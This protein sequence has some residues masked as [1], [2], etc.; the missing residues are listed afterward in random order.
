[1]SLGKFTK[2]QIFRQ[3][4]SG[5]LTGS[6]EISGRP[7]EKWQKVA[8]HPVFYDEFMK[9]LLG[10][11]F[12][13]ES[14]SEKSAVGSLSRVPPVADP[15]IPQQPT[16]R[17]ELEEEKRG[18]VGPTVQAKTEFMDGATVQESDLR[19]LFSES[20]DK[21][22]TE[23]VSNHEDKT[24]RLDEAL[25]ADDPSSQLIPIKVSPDPLGTQPLTERSFPASSAKR[26]PA[27]R[28]AAFI[29]VLGVLFYVSFPSFYQ[30][31]VP[32]KMTQE[33]GSADTAESLTEREKDDRVRSLLEEG[34]EYYRLDL[35]P[36]YQQAQEIYREAL[37]HY[38]TNPEALARIAETTARI[39]PEIKDSKGLE[40]AVREWLEKGRAIDPHFS[41][42]YR[43]EAL[44]LLHQKRVDEASKALASAMETNATDPDN[45]IV[46]AEIEWAK[47]NTLGAKLALTE[48]IHKKSPDVRSRLLLARLFLN[49]NELERAQKIAIESLS[50]NPLAPTAYWILGNIALRVNSLAQAKQHFES[51]RN[52]SL[53]ATRE[54]AGSSF[55]ELGKIMERLNETDQASLYF[56]VAYFYNPE[57]VGL[58]EKVSAYSL[59][60]KELG[61]LAIDA[62]YTRE[63]LQSRGDQF[64]DQGKYAEAGK[65]FLAASLTDRKDGNSLVRLGETIENTARSFVD[66]QKVINLY[67]RAIQRDPTLVSGYVRLGLLETTQ[68]NFDRAHKLLGQALALAPN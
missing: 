63:A 58:R 42:F 50:I 18:G 60:E 23:K 15:E 10:D 53:F 52:L 35:P 4:S 20:I 17:A 9:R 32:V 61:K 2:E 12:K 43:V 22:G 30:T 41:P 62:A 40:R 65:F 66:F 25:P 51:A 24:A 57:I 59:E 21:A 8:S 16:R 39:I 13:G 26:V 56:R 6:E 29:L 1:M 44:I 7:F 48:A 37:F 19:E 28:I 36:A 49:E 64:F 68:Y 14:P 67:Q 11:E 33:A 3:I 54:V 31:Q 55:F 34:N 5:Q 45:A 46:K 38:E 47:G 27:I